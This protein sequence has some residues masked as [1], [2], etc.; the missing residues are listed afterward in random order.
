M[1]WCLV[2][3]RASF[4][5]LLFLSHF[6]QFDWLSD[7]TVIMTCVAVN[8]KVVMNDKTIQTWA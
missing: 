1:A 7:D 4:T 2:K 5:C 6:L 3:L 8:G